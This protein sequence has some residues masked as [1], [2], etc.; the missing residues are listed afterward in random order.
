MPYATLTSKGQTTIPKEVRERLRLKTGARM[1]FTVES[2]DRAVLRPVDDDISSLKGLLARPGR[3]KLSMEEM[4]EA[5]KKAVAK[6]VMRGL[7]YRKSKR[8][9]RSA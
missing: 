4:D 7:G 8:P 9:R 1:E 3:R 5:M 2:D 6:D